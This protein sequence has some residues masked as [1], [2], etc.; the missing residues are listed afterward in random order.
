[1]ASLTAT[2]QSAPAPRTLPLWP[3]I[4]GC[5]LV[6]LL[7]LRDLSVFAD[8][9]IGHEAV[10]GRDFANLWTGGQLLNAGRVDILTNIRPYQHFQ[11]S[12][13]GPLAPHNYSYPPVSYPI[14]QLFAL[15]PYPAAL[16]AWIVATGALFMRACQP[17]WPK[18]AGPQWLAVLTPA[19]LLN[20]WAGHY[21]F[22][23]GAI[24]L[25][26]WHNLDRRPVLARR[27]LR[28]DADQAA[29]C[30]ARPARP[31]AAARMDRD[32]GRG[33]HRNRARCHYRRHLRLGRW[34]YFLFH[35]SVVQAGMIDAGRSF[36]GLLSTSFA[37]A[38]L[39]T[40]DSW[41]LAVVGQL[42]FA[43]G[44]VILVVL[45]VR[46]R[47]PTDKLGLLVASATFMA[48]P[49][50]FAYDLTVVTM[51]AVVVMAAG[52]FAKQDRRWATFGFMA[53]SLGILFAFA[54]I[55]LMPIL[56]ALLAIAQFRAACGPIWVKPGGAAA[57]A[58]P[59]AAT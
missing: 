52:D 21:G 45:A 27:L 57:R 10:W 31:A 16:A 15:L 44:G 55:P 13:F 59:A 11:T 35:T 41:L 5:G 54:G 22:L 18:D 26:G 28:A 3:W 8:G 12:L 14:A 6:L 33:R 58:A 40:T 49:Y 17:W 29:P 20:I 7:F 25:F 30:P 19:A 36:F 24:F 56:I 42:L 1:M 4:I 48:L 37:T 39:R 46:R 34:R 23:L 51:G 9:R 43:L 53:P 50:A 38:A 2:D 47:C 32:A